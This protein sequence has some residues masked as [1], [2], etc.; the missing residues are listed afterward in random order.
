LPRKEQFNQRAGSLAVA[1]SDAC[2]A[3]DN[4]L[5]D[6]LAKRYTSPVTFRSIPSTSY[7]VLAH[8]VGLAHVEIIEGDWRRVGNMTLMKSPRYAFTARQIAELRRQFD[9]HPA[10]FFPGKGFPQVR[11]AIRAA[12]APLVVGL[13]QEA[14]W[15]ADNG[16]G[17][18]QFDPK[19]GTLSVGKQRYSLEGTEADV[20]KALVDHGSATLN[21]LQRKSG[22]ET[23]NKVLRRLVKKYPALA[24]YIAFPGA[25]G[26]GGYSTTITPLSVGNSL[27]TI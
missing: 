10:L 13:R 8:D 5:R 21:T 15:L 23:P 18:P 17:E 4:G 20:L 6:R 24:E 27:P 7:A 26:K 25:R 1:F 12:F 16:Q 11:Q 9:A 22:C 2:E 14:A 3:L 19:A